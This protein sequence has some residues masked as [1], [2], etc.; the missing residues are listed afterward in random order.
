MKMLARRSRQANGKTSWPTDWREQFAGEDK[1]AL[2]QLQRFTQPADVAKALLAAQQRIRSGEYKRQ[3]GEDATPEQ[4]KE[5]RKEQGIPDDPK[6]YELPT[7]MDGKYDDLDEFG[8]ESFDAMRAAFHAENLRPEAAAKIMEV[9]N[10][11]AVKQMER[12]AEQDAGRMETT[13]DTLRADWGAEFRKNINL[14]AHFLNDK[15]GDTWTNVIEARMPDG[16][17]LADLP[18][19]SKFINEMARMDGGGEVMMTGEVAGAQGIDAR[20]AEIENIM[21]TDLSKYDGATQAE[22]GKLLEARDRRKR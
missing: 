19:F 2:K 21:K 12:Q 4:I 14:N 16:T 1:K 11:L 17:R 8:K 15:L 6:G 9:A 7:L 18:A 10:N 5:W 20:I 13:E 22:Y 3:L